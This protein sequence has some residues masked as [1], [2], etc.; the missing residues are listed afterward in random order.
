LDKMKNKA[1]NE[2]ERRLDRRDKMDMALQHLAA[3]KNQASKGRKY[4]EKSAEDGRPAV[5]KWK[6]QRKR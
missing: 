4:K 1:Y 3:K 5:Y 6:Q 2:L